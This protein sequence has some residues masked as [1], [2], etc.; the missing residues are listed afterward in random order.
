MSC[1][2]ETSFGYIS[3]PNSVNPLPLEGLGRPTSED[4]FAY[5]DLV[6]HLYRDTNQSLGQIQALLGDRYNFNAT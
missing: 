6:V 4:W 1:L 5:R 2:G 3:G